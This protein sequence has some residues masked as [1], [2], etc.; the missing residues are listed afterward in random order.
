MWLSSNLRGWEWQ[1][2]Y[3]LEKF[4]HLG[5]PVFGCNRRALWP[6]QMH[7]WSAWVYVLWGW[8]VGVPVF[9][10]S[11]VGKLV[12]LGL[13]FLGLASWCAWF[14]VFWGWQ[15][16][17]LGFVFS[18]VGKLVCP[19]CFNRGVG[20]LHVHLHC[21]T[22]TLK[23]LPSIS[24]QYFFNPFFYCFIIVFPSK[25]LNRLVYLLINWYTILQFLFLLFL[26]MSKI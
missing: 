14:C 5:N 7:I 4:T 13:Y 17:V 25:L 22:C 9:M 20:M 2:A 19:A 10:F 24:S 8:E 18:V 6:K 12:C 21:E 26:K 23:C 11:G 1:N 3:E 15:V 16:G